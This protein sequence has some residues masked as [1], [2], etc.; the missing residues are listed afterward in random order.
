MADDPF[1]RERVAVTLRR[2]PAYLRLAWR[3]AR[4]PLA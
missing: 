3:L 2:L 4:D 1:P